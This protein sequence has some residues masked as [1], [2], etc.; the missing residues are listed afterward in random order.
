MPLDLARDTCSFL[1]PL[2]LFLHTLL[3]WLFIEALVQG[4]L[5]ERWFRDKGDESQVTKG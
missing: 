3:Q 4:V 1:E 5:E 2:N